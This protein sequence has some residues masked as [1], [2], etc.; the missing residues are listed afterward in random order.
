MLPS[1]SEKGRPQSTCKGC[2]VWSRTCVVR[3]PTAAQ[4]RFIL[5]WRCSRCTQQDAVHTPAASKQ[6]SHKS[7]YLLGNFVVC[8]FGL[9][10]VH[11]RFGKGLT[12]IHQVWIISS[13][14]QRGISYEFI[15]ISWDHSWSFRSSWT[16]M[17][18]GASAGVAV[19]CRC[20]RGTS[21]V[22]P[23]GSGCQDIFRNKACWLVQVVSLSPFPMSNLLTC[24]AM[25]WNCGTYSLQSQDKA[26]RLYQDQDTLFTNVHVAFD[27]HYFNFFQFSPKNISQTHTT[28]SSILRPHQ[29]TPESPGGHVCC[30]CLMGVWHNKDAS[31]YRISLKCIVMYAVERLRQ[32]A[33]AFIAT[34]HRIMHKICLTCQQEFLRTRRSMLPQNAV[35]PSLLKLMAPTHPCWTK[36]LA[37]DAG[38]CAPERITVCTLL[39]L[40]SCKWHWR[41]RI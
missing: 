33:Y 27:V 2:R 4:R 3:V 10:L 12:K 40:P 20:R 22:G 32:T 7:W 37:A 17:F 23:V 19:V 5:R 31:Y 35:N 9:V 36:M 15:L 34:L 18:F 8:L 26:A 28:S 24:C 21:P 25:W 1:R 30:S 6:K 16:A 38:P 39:F 29:R 13:L 11:H 41:S 14:F